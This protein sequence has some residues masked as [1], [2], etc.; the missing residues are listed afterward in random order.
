MEINAPELLT[1]QHQ[2]QNFDCGETSLNVWLQR[3]ALK[4][5]HNQSSRTFVV[6]NQDNEVVGF[7]ALAAG[8]VTHTL[9]SR[10]LRQNMPDPIPVVVLGR[11]AVDKRAQGQHLG[12]S[13]LKDAVL[14]AKAVAEQ[15]A[16]KALLVHALNESAKRFYLNYGFQVSPIDEWVL[17][18]K[19]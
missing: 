3:H 6:C 18:L 12:A 5:Q 10:G 13:L 8:S 4:N 7:Y 15:I 17:W 19:L 1:A 16:V 14:R 2:T 11:L 9:V